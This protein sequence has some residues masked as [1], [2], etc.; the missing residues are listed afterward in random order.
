MSDECLSVNTNG[1]R[2]YGR[3]MVSSQ[4]RLSEMF[5]ACFPAWYRQKKRLPEVDENQ[6]IPVDAC[7]PKQFRVRVGDNAG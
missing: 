5:Y 3:E 1:K 2:Q 6:C 7:K 4:Y